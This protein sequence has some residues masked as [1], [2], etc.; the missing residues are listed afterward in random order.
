MKIWLIILTILY[1]IL[2]EFQI[3][4]QKQI[5]ELEERKQDR[6]EIKKNR[7]SG[8]NIESHNC[9][10][11]KKGI[12]HCECGKCNPSSIEISDNRDNCRNNSS[13]S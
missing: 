11:D 10:R 5:N 1:C 9:G 12:F 4:E 8:N 7:V 3:D 2:I 13:N 6:L